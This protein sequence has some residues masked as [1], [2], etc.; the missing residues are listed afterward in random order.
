VNP[1][2]DPSNCG[3]CGNFC[4]SGVCAFNTGFTSGCMPLP[5]ASCGDA[6]AASCAVSMQEGGS[7]L[8]GLCELANDS[9]G[10]CCESTCANLFSD[11]ANCGGCGYQC[12]SGQTCQGGVCSGAVAACGPG[13]VDAFCDVDAGLSFLCCGGACTNTLSDPSN[14]GGCGDVCQGSPS[15]VA[16]SCQ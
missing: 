1:Y 2:E 11:P 8:P 10:L 12:P 16:G 3:T 13:S 15:C 14:C 6:C 7:P 4:V 5:D 9:V